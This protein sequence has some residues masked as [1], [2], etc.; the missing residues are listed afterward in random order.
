[1]VTVVYNY[2][3]ENFGYVDNNN[4]V[5]FDKKYQTFSPKDLKKALKKLK[6]E[7]GDVLEIKFVAKKLRNLLNKPNNTDQHNTNNHDSAENDHDSQISENVWGYAKK[8]SLRKVKNTS[9][10][11]SF[12]LT[13]CT[14][15]FAKTFT[16]INSIL[17]VK[18]TFSI[19]SW[20]PK[21]ASPQKPFDLYPPTY[22]E[23][24]NVIRKM[25]PSGSPCPL[26]QISIIFFKRCPYLR[27]YLTE[28]I[29]AA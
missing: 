22:Q 6:L 18:H 24:T 19:P 11:A 8:F 26:D 7:N 15:Y 13:Q 14:F 10:L 3:G 5:E 12:N 23:I 1:M 4:S 16:S 21:F 20:I 17:Q 29:H 25:K 27:S 28:I 9:S 2:F